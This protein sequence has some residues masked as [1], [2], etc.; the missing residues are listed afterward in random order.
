MNLGETSRWASESEQ[1]FFALKEG[2]SFAFH[3]FYGGSV[4][5]GSKALSRFILLRVGYRQ[6]TLGRQ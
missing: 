3:E 2:A 5:F 4:C 1:S 6:G